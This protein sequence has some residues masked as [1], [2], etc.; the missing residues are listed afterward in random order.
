[1]VFAA[2]EAALEVS[3]AIRGAEGERRV[4]CGRR[5]RRAGGD[6]KPRR[7]GRVA[8]E[9]GLSDKRRRRERPGRNDKENAP[10]ARAGAGR[11]QARPEPSSHSALP[12]TQRIG[13]IE[14]GQPYIQPCPPLPLWRPSGPIRR[15]HSPAPSLNRDGAD[16]NSL[17]SDKSRHGSAISTQFARSP[18]LSRS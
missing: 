17:V 11:E 9:H 14:P 15:I 7:G 12:R 13:S 10:A 18:P 5:P 8:V 6:L 16:R 3:N 1:L 2:I 4:R